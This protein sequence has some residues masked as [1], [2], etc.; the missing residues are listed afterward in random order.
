MFD[1]ILNP[2][3]FTPG[4]DLSATIFAVLFALLAVCLEEHKRARACRQAAR[5]RR[6]Y[7]RARRGLRP[8]RHGVARIPRPRL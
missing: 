1:F 7:P 8:G 3:N 2:P 5:R 6:P 4:W